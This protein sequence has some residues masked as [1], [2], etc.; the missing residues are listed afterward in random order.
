M[1]MMFG[2]PL[3]PVPRDTAPFPWELSDH[4]HG[5]V[6]RLG[7]SEGP[8]CRHAVKL[9]V[10]LA[11]RC[12]VNGAHTVRLR[13]G[14]P[15]ENTKLLQLQEAHF[16]NRAL[17]LGILFVG[18]YSD[19]VFIIRALLMNERCGGTVLDSITEEPM[20]PSEEPLI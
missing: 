15:C 12:R 7:L 4:L 20:R 19:A 8:C 17:L 1:N 14:D 3:S 5:R 16:I 6:T 2:Y 18:I 9:R 10:L 13:W 11:D